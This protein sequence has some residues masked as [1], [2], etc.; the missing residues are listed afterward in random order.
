MAPDAPGGHAV[1]APLTPPLV[2]LRPLVSADAAT[3]ASWSL[4]PRFVAGADWTPDLS[5]EVHVAFQLRI[6]TDPPADLI[7]LGAVHEGELVG[8]VDLHG[9][10]PRRREL[11]Y[12]IGDSHRWGRGYGGAAARAGLA[13]GFGVL[14]LT[15][16]WAEA[17]TGNTASV[18]ILQGLGMTE[19]DHGA[20][21][22][23]RRF[24]ISVGS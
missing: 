4:D 5:L 7:R 12:V 18:R 16:I 17:L 22:P 2:E 11:G 20:P 24:T 21:G 8:Y 15:E 1:P 14:G 9:H 23:Y 6:V 13:Y 10:E 3:I 19:I